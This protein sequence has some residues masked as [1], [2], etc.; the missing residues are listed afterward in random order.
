MCIFLILLFSNVQLWVLHILTFTPLPTGWGRRTTCFQCGLMVQSP[1]NSL[2]HAARFSPH[3]FCPGVTLNCLMYCHAIVPCTMALLG[4]LL[5]CGVK[6]RRMDSPSCISVQQW[7]VLVRYV[8]VWGDGAE[9]RVCYSFVG[10]AEAWG[11]QFNWVFWLYC[12]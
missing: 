2:S 1:T 9:F 4:C 8:W 11:A 12:F 6:G 5:E 3:S 10:L 7:R